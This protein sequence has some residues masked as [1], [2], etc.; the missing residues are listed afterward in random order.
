[1][2]TTNTNWINLMPYRG[3]QYEVF[4]DKGTG[5]FHYHGNINLKV[6]DRAKATLF[7]EYDEYDIVLEKETTYGRWFCKIIGEKEKYMVKKDMITQIYI[8]DGY[9]ERRNI[10][11]VHKTTKNQL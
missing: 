2:R 11:K 5:W 1:M 9:R 3:T 8:D 4:R 7:N 6:G 10:P